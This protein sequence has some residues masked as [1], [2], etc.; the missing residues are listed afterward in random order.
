MGLIGAQSGADLPDMARIRPKTRL[1]WYFAGVALPERFPMAATGCAWRAG[2]LPAPTPGARTGRRPAVET[3]GGGCLPHL[4]DCRP[5]T[6]VTP[7]CH[8]ARR[9]TNQANRSDLVI[10]LNL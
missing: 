9:V 7:D 2:Q 1:R 3:D 8:S 4:P 10:L 5:G 6:I